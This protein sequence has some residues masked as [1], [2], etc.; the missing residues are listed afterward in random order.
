MKN[1]FSILSLCEHLEVSPSG[2]YDWQ[3]R[4]ACPGPRALEDQILA[5]TIEQ[6]FLQSQRTYGSPRIMMLLRN[7]SSDTLS[8]T[9][10]QTSQPLASHSAPFATFVSLL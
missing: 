10:P 8:R 4:R 5:T 6:I 9:L 3:K 2:Y 7:T 1:D